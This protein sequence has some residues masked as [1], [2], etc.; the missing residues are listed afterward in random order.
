MK[1]VKTISKKNKQALQAY[2]KKIQ[3]EAKSD[4]RNTIQGSPNN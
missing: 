4:D 3:D 2:F 1:K